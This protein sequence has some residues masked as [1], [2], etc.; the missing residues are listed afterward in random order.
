[1]DIINIFKDRGT[2]ALSP[3]F[4]AIYLSYQN[5]NNLWL[6]CLFIALSTFTYFLIAEVLAKEISKKHLT[7]EADVYKEAVGKNYRIYSGVA[8]LMQWT[9]NIISLIL[10]SGYLND[11]VAYTLFCISISCFVYNLVRVMII[12]SDIIKKSFHGEL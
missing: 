8:S 12:H 3:F 7:A 4:I 2:I 5:F 9:L 11:F 10:L 1:M 6:P